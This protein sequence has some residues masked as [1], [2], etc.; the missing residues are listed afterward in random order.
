[1]LKPWSRKPLFRTAAEWNLQSHMIL[2]V[3][4]TA[5]GRMNPQNRIRNFRIRSRTAAETENRLS[6]TE[7]PYNRS[8]G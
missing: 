7:R 3:I 6:Y 5:A 1:M 8:K 4:R 2:T